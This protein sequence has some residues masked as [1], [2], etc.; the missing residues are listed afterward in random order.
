M[1][2]LT[3]Y[4]NTENTSQF[5]R[6]LPFLKATFVFVMCFLM[7][8]LQP[9]QAK[10]SVNLSPE[11]TL[12]YENGQVD[13]N[14]GIIDVVNAELLYE[15]EVQFNAHTLIAKFDNKSEPENPILKMLDIS[16]L[17]V[18]HDDAD[19]SIGQITFINLPLTFDYPLSGQSEPDEIIAY[20]NRQHDSHFK[21]ADLEINLKEADILV[22]IDEID[23][24]GER[25]KPLTDNMAGVKSSYVISNLSITR[26]DKDS[27]A[28]RLNEMLAQLGLNS[29]RQDIIG[30][31]ES[32]YQDRRV[33]MRLHQNFDLS[34]LVRFSWDLEISLGHSI[35]DLGAFFVNHI[36]IH[37]LSENDDLDDFDL[38]EE[39]LRNLLL[40]SMGEILVHGA[41][42]E[43]EDKGVMAVM[44]E[45][46]M[47]VQMMEDSFQNL[48]E[49]I[50]DLL[51]QPVT[52]FIY[53]GG[54]LA[55]DANPQTP[56]NLLQLGTIMI[57][58]EVAIQSLGLAVRHQKN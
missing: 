4:K 48:P 27:D 17:S 29:I 39:E 45:P 41:S 54:I 7:A 52:D 38:P 43:L 25:I 19:I 40:A 47:F 11:F 1:R 34:Q 55:V 51:R 56:A 57:A 6:C 49:P 15:G 16:G 10:N 9:V 32:R 24:S 5:W 22:S 20:L 44:P 50:A 26:Y 23:A 8:M 14:A 36:N 28:Q 30:G 58:P 37:E 13:M 35:F 21:L 33:S 53:H 2:A 12:N 3:G 46:D 18:E 42:V 31:N